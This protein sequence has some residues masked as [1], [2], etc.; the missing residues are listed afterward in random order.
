MAIAERLGRLRRIGLQTRCVHPSHRKSAPT[1]ASRRTR[2]RRSYLNTVDSQSHREQ[3]F[4]H[5]SGS[6]TAQ[7]ALWEHAPG[8]RP[9]EHWPARP[10]SARAHTRGGKRSPQ[11][12]RIA[13]LAALRRAPGQGSGIT[14]GSKRSAWRASLFAP[15]LTVSAGNSAETGSQ[16]TASTTIP[17]RP[18][19]PPFHGGVKLAEFRGFLGVYERISGNRDAPFGALAPILRIRLCGPICATKPS[20]QSLL[21]L[22][23]REPG[24]QRCPRSRDP[25]AAGRRSDLPGKKCG[26]QWASCSTHYNNQN[27][28]YFRVGE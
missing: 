20:V 15:P 24:Q 26:L 28:P 23:A 19:T 27:G 11:P 18:E 3:S 13:A 4:L 21:F 5:L 25:F 12:V 6:P 9:V 10:V 14:S 8:T 22:C 1:L 16:Q 7:H 2:R 17:F